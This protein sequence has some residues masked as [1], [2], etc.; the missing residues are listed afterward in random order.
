MTEREALKYLGLTPETVME[1]CRREVEKML[2]K[3]TP[4]RLE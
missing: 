3:L 1:W 2:V 4:W